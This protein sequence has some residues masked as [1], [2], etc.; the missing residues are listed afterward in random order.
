MQSYSAKSIK[1][2][3]HFRVGDLSKVVGGLRKAVSY[4]T[5]KPS[6][7]LQSAC[8]PLKQLKTLVPSSCSL[9]F[10]GGK[11]NKKG[12]S[13]SLGVFSIRS[14]FFFHTAFCI[15]SIPLRLSVLTGSLLTF[16]FTVTA[17][18][19]ID[20]DN[21]KTGIKKKKGIKNPT[22]VKTLPSSPKT[23]PVN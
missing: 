1:V 6:K 3:S 10:C 7:C 17:Q 23:L 12:K 22:S 16:P 4:C 9:S 5:H 14:L 13:M 8:L 11:K 21:W 2:S 20:R 18:S 15:H 19:I